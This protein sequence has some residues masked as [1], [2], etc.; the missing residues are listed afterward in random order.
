MCGI[1][2]ILHL[3][4]ERTAQAGP[5]QRMTDVIHHRGPDGEGHFL[6]GNLG[7]GHRRLSIIDLHSGDQPMFSDDGH[8]AIVFNGE[9]Y[10]YVE[11]REELRSMGFAFQTTSD[12]EVILTAY[13]A[14]GIAC[15]ERLNGM[16]AFALWDEKEQQLLISRDRAGEK[17]LNYARYDNTLLFGS[18]IKSLLAYGMDA[19]PNMDMLEL[20]MFLGYL[21]EPYT[22]YRDI[23]KLRSGHYLLIRD[24]QVTEASYWDLPQVEDGDLRVDASTVVEQFADLFDDAVRIRMRSDVPFGAFLSGGLDSSSVVAAMADHSKQPVETFTIGFEEKAFDESDKA[25]IVAEQFKTRHHL[26]IVSPDTFDEALNFVLHHYDEPFADPAAIPTGYVARS[27]RKHVK[28]ALTGDGGDEVLCGYTTY[29]SERMATQYD[30]LPGMVKKILPVAVHNAAGLFNGNLRY[31]FNRMDRVITAFN[32]PFQQRLISKFVKIPPPEVK[33]LMREKHHPVEDFIREALKGCTLSDPFHQLNYF[34]LKV[35]LPGQML[36]KVDKMAMA[37]SLET[38]APFLDPRLIDLMYPVHKD[39]K[40]PTRHDQSVKHV[41][42]EA[43]KDRLPN[44]IVY[45]QKMGFEVP[46]REW[47]KDKSFEEKLAV[48]TVPEVMDGGR[49]RQLI[50]DNRSGKNDN[51]T[52]IWRIILL[53]QWLQQF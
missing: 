9:I 20:Y 3:D 32:A 39:V 5:L 29:Q 44:S 6:K 26:D 45:R 46:L 52:F 34:Q 49:I 21:P 15:Q 12:T 50:E 22:F 17:P 37:H 16:W 24:G 31:K 11:L 14:W 40:V 4:R 25:R 2:G 48:K 18:E 7:L 1:A 43:M 41:L 23:H 13:Q 53:D 36:V 28:M 33:T 10:N 19:R 38:R 27:A 30:Q 47:F 8:L 51:G 35:S 42:K